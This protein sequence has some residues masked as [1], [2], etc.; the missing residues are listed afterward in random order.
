[1]FC[2][3]RWPASV[4]AM[5]SSMQDHLQRALQGDFA[6]SL[7]EDG[8]LPAAFMVGLLGASLVFAQASHTVN[9]A[10]KANCSIDY[11]CIAQ[12]TQASMTT[13]RTSSVGG[14]HGFD[15]S[16]RVRTCRLQ[17]HWHRAGGVDGCGGRQRRVDGLLE[18]G[19]LPHAR[20]RRR[21]V[22]RVPGLTLH[23]QAHPLQ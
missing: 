20:R 3:S 12:A 2:M 5:P 16:P 11:C 6:L 9:G 8:V 4:A 14:A 17:A 23:R 1:M 21:G 22:L 10:S 15:T 7:F 18:P 13:P 19:L